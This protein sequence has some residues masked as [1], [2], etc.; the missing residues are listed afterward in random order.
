[1]AALVASHA[2]SRG[3]REIEMVKGGGDRVLVNTGERM[4]VVVVRRDFL[5][6]EWS[7]VDLNFTCS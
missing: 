6:R 5:D 4:I 7:S 3:T 1:M 2:A